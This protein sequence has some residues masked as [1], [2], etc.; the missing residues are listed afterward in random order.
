M[1]NKIDRMAKAGF[2]Q[3]WKNAPEGQRQVWE[4]QTEECR[5]HWRQIIRAILLEKSETPQ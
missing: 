2:D 1:S 4:G 3:A 5:D